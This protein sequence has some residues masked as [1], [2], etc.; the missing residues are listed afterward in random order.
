M[1]PEFPKPLTFMLQILTFETLVLTITKLSNVRTEIFI[2][3]VKPYVNVN[4]LRFDESIMR[5][6]TVS[7]SASELFFDALLVAFAIASFD[8]LNIKNKEK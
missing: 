7:D 4:V 1:I 3:L 2:C 6:L 8:F 5:E